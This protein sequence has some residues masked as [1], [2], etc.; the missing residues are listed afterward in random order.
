[1]FKSKLFCVIFTSFLLVILSSCW[2]RSELNEFALALAMGIDK[3]DDQY[4][5]T[6]QVVQPQEVKEPSYY[7][8]VT[9]YTA[10]AGSIFEALRKIT[11]E[12]PRKISVPHLRILVLSEDLA[13]EGI[14]EV[15]EMITRDHAYRPDFYTVVSRGNS[16][17]E[18]L[19]VMTRLER[20]PANKLFSS[21]VTS[22]TQWAPTVGIQIDKLIRELSSESK[23]AVLTGIKIEGDPESGSTKQTVE[24]IE[25]LTSLIYTDVAVF[26][27][28]KLVGWLNENESK[29]YNYILGN[30]QS[31]VGGAMCPEDKEGEAII[32]VIRT[33]SEI[34]G[35]IENDQPNIDINLKLEGNIGELKCDIDISNEHVLKELEE[36]SENRLKDML[37]TTIHTVQADYNSDIFGFGDVLH[38][39]NPDKWKEIEG[40]W[41]DEGFQEV[42]VNVSVECNYNHTGTINRSFNS[43]FKE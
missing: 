11:L 34:K 13:E 16:A 17:E 10:Q 21:L 29:G 35:K 36:L 40:A 7:V 27:K 31:T 33:S 32:E 25:P 39:S 3:S 20:I 9:T 14:A 42:N 2:N 43:K 26:K 22:E 19:S 23:Q 4:K 37:L 38:R 12:S 28:D 8:P 24:Q 6:V 15:L 5:L 1:M 18:V 41:E 30:V